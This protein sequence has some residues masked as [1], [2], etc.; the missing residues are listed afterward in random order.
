MRPTSGTRMI[1]CS[2]PLVHT[3][4]VKIVSTTQLAHSHQVQ[5]LVTYNAG[6]LGDDGDGGVG[7]S[8]GVVRL[9]Q[10]R[11]SLQ[12]DCRGDFDTLGVGVFFYSL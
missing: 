12:S 2:K 10:L 11:Y 4:L 6:T 7:R 9:D 8:G 1:L 3:V 5:S